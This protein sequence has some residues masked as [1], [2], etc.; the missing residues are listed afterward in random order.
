MRARAGAPGTG[1]EDDRSLLALIVETQRDIA[2]AGS[3]VEAVM[4]LVLARSQA[5]TGA[6]GAMVSLVDGDELLTRAASGISA[7]L[8]GRR[9]P[10]RETVA[11][12]A[13]EGRVPLLI[14][15]RKSESLICVPLFQ[16]EQVIGALSVLG[17]SET[18]L[19]ERNRQTMEM[20]SVILS[21]A[22]S[23][24]ALVAQ[25][26]LSEYQAVHDAL[27]DLP[28]RTLFRQRIAH[29]VADGEA[30]GGFAVV[31]MDLDRFKEINDS[32]GHHAGDALLVEVARRVEGALR[33]SDMVA[34]L[35]GDEFGLLLRAPT[36]TAGLE[37]VLDL[38]R[39]AI[40]APIMFHDVPLA[41]SASMGVAAFP[42][43]G[44]D[45]ETLLRHAD[46]A[47]Y[48]AKR[49]DLPFALYDE[50][51]NRSD[52]SRLALIAEL[53]RGLRRREL[54]LHYQPK[55]RLASGVVDS[56]EALVRWNH[57]ERGLVFP[58]AF[59][60]L[61]QETGLI[62]PL[63]R[64]VLEE[65]VR[66]AREWQLA[67]LELAV[68]VNLSA[69]NLLDVEFPDQVER[70]LT[71]A[72]LP[73]ALLELEITE[74][75]MLSDGARTKSALDRLSGLGI[76]ISIDDFGTGYSSSLAS[77]RRLPI[78]EIKI[79]RSFV[80]NMDG[81]ED[82]AVIVRST[83]DL[84]RNLGL[85]VVAE[86]V[87]SERVWTELRRLGCTSAQGYYLTRPV[88]AGELEAWLAAREHDQAA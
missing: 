75:T 28:N 48:A 86:G 69:R 29:A 50:A 32:M 21:A 72:G 15:D 88:P 58:D 42:E 78:S 57:P 6:D 80:M 84:G 71:E 31:I 45:V 55:A 38:V 12:A 70:L 22:V 44:R 35:G 82:D 83:I 4:E 74:T 10:L 54:V 87:E 3:N 46:V 33:T 5:L 13:I 77:L 47:M 76:R 36:G 26:E 85:S 8:V 59:I 62:R 53:R 19:D 30:E 16:G 40:E 63:T 20:V 11:R 64:H 2:A 56:V 25:S 1:E 37:T 17:A 49:S 73:P 51:D 41:I 68:S 66:Q 23:Y 65:A 79:D 9:R 34:R 81:C 39:E 27:T 60:P 7:G 14:S 61:A 24:A 18:R 43:H 67:G 52:P